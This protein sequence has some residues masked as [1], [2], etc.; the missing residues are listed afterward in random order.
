[1]DLSHLLEFLG[2]FQEKFSKIYSIASWLV[3]AVVILWIYNLVAGFIQKT[4]SLGKGIGKIYRNYFHRY[5]K[6]AFVQLF[7]L[8]ASKDKISQNI[9]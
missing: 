2:T 5:L 1:M 7:E 9:Q 6:A 4:Y 3:S 8:V